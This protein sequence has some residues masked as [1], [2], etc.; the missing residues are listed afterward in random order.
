MKLAGMDFMALFISESDFPNFAMS[1]YNCQT[2]YSDELPHFEL[3]VDGGYVM[4]MCAYP[5]FYFYLYNTTKGETACW[6]D[7]N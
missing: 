6:E 5:R 7:E 2:P 1:Y 4:F 3:H